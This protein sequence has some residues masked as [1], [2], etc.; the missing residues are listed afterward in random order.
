METRN[1]PS[2]KEEKPLTR[3]Y[4]HVNT[5]TVS[6]FAYRCKD[7]QNE[8]VRKREQG[9]RKHHRENQ[10]KLFPKKETNPYNVITETDQWRAWNDE[11]GIKY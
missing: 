6:G 1:C 7:C 11:R 9:L 3:E 5:S 4:Y 2:C 8:Y 10:G